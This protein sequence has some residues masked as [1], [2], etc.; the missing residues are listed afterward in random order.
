MLLI[1]VWHPPIWLSLA[2]IVGV[3]G[4][5]AVL[6]LRVKPTPK[7]VPDRSPATIPPA[8]IAV[9]GGRPDRSDAE[10]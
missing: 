9:A 8:P 6:S 10:I 5:T 4:L 3:L 2:A 7:E 1:D